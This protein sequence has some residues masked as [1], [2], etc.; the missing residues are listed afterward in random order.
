MTA[1][2]E[3][4]PGRPTPGVGGATFVMRR[5]YFLGESLDA[6]MCVKEN[7]DAGRPPFPLSHAQLVRAASS[8]VDDTSSASA[9]V[10]DNDGGEGEVGGR[11]GAEGTKRWWQ[12]IGSA[13]TS[14]IRQNSSDEIRTLTSSSS[15]SSSWL[16]L[17]D[18]CL[19]FINS[20]VVRSR[21]KEM[22]SRLFHV[23][24]HIERADVGFVT[25][26]HNGIYCATWS[27]RDDIELCN[28]SSECE[29]RLF[30]QRAGIRTVFTVWQ[31]KQC[32]R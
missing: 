21:A 23:V 12:I 4:H 7:T 29:Q 18:L 15:S 25:N 19:G 11:G 8:L 2:G 3:C 28:A 9:V 5:L 1:G 24:D 26:G 17:H 6:E 30:S 14:W 31:Q 22:Q 32:A 20:E 10:D 16:S 13:S 27:N